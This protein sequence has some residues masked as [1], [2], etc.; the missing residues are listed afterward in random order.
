LDAS[1]LSVKWAFKT[2]GGTY[3]GA[4]VMDATGNVFHPGISGDQQ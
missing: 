1:G 4:Y 3:A 2:G